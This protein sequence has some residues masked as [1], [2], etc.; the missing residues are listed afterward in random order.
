MKN[1]LKTFA[2]ILVT[3]VTTQGQA[4]VNDPI[5]GA[6]NK[7]LDMLNPKLLKQVEQVKKAKEQLREQVA[8]TT[9]SETTAN[10]EMAEIDY[11]S[12]VSKFATNFAVSG[13]KINDLEQKNIALYNYNVSLLGQLPANQPNQLKYYAHILTGVEKTLKNYQKQGELLGYK[14]SGSISD[15]GDTFGDSS[16][17]LTGESSN[18]EEQKF[19]DAKQKADDI[20]KQYSDKVGDLNAVYQKLLKAVEDDKGGFLKKLG[21]GILNIGS[22]GFYNKAKDLIKDG[23]K[24]AIDSWFNGEMKEQD[25]WFNGEMKGL[26]FDE[27]LSGSNGQ[28]GMQLGK[29]KRVKIDPKDGYMDDYGKLA[30][31]YNIAERYEEINLIL[32]GIARE[33]EG[34]IGKDKVLTKFTSEVK[35]GTNKYSGTRK[36]ENYILDTQDDGSGEF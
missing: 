25:S 26:G 24:S 20:A 16:G 29:G 7:V 10:A 36:K 17:G 34:I 19:V 27:L 15:L 23:S 33:M 32:T 8:I 6:L 28:L 21:E 9:A 14:K 22:L 5:N 18:A 11:Q 31:G 30:L 12:N 1:I 4:I 13:L 35:A 2:I 3:V